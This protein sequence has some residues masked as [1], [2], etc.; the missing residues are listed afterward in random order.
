VFV[1]G[2]GNG[3]DSRPLQFVASD[4]RTESVPAA[5][6]AFS[7]VK[8]SP[9]GSR[10]AVQIDVGDAADVWV[11]EVARGTLTRVTTETGYDGNPLWSPDGQSVAFLSTRAG[12]WT[13]NRKAADGTG[14]VEQLAAFPPVTTLMYATG[15]TADGILLTLDGNIGVV[16]ADGKSEWTP[17]IQSAAA[18]LQGVLSPDGRWLAYMST[19]TGA[20]EVYLQR[21]PGLGE[22]QLASVGGGSMPTWSHDGHTLTYLRGRGGPPQEIMR[23]TIAST[24]NG[25]ARISA[26]S[27]VADWN[28][29]TAQFAPRVYDISPDGRLLVIGRTADE[30]PTAQRQINVVVNWFEELKRLVP[31][32]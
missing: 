32:P 15:W 20:P 10:I 2:T 3:G 12:R 9:D 17:L 6:R 18:E 11:V 8:L 7:G 23:V 24:G 13:L 28:F 5:P 16:A 1:P 30:K 22:R 14:P 19:E 26:P 21:F 29:Y 27:K 25:S 4:G 31:I